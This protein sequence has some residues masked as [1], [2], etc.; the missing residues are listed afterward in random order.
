[1]AN[2]H[3]LMGFVRNRA[4]GSVYIE[5]EGTPEQCREFIG[6]CNRGPNFGRVDHVDVTESGIVNFREFEIRR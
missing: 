2:L 6:W 1:M 4:D 3:N 5:I